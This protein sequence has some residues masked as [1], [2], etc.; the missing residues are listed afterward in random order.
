VPEPADL[1]V[2]VVS[3]VDKRLKVKE[4]F[5]NIFP[6]KNYPAEFPYRSKV[7]QTFPEYSSIIYSKLNYFFT[8]HITL[9]LQEI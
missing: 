1:V 4:Q 2:R 6:E 3:S 8:I 9:Q 7:S 5:L